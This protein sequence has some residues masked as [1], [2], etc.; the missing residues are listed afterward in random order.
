MEKHK[1]GQPVVC[2]DST[3]RQI[4]GYRVGWML[5]AMNLV[6]YDTPVMVLDG[7]LP[8]W[9]KEGRKTEKIDQDLLYTVISDN[10]EHQ[11]FDTSIVKFTRDVSGFEF[12]ARKG[13]RLPFQLVDTR[14]PEEF[15]KGHISGALNIPFTKFFT[16]IDGCKVMRPP[17][18]RL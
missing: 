8:K 17:T 18:E 5:R 9:L 6:P 12:A 7:G 11:D 15:A 4:F 14:V 10:H 16:T 3:E 2:Y 13:E 1:K